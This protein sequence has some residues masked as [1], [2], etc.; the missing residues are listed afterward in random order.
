MMI[1]LMFWPWKRSEQP[2]GSAQHDRHVRFWSGCLVA[3]VLSTGCRGRSEDSVRREFEAY[4]AAINHC[5][6]VAECTTI[7]PGCPLGCQVAVPARHK[8]AAMSKAR[9]LIDQYESGGTSC[10]YECALTGP[11]VCEQSRCTLTPTG[12][13]TTPTDAGTDAGTDTDAGG[14]PVSRG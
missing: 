14:S 7:G 8:D 10:L 4:L 2:V 13:S 1:S 9:D 5:S 11:L 3:L 6:S 12:S